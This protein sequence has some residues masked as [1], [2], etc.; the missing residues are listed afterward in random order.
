LASFFWSSSQSSYQFIYQLP[1]LFIETVSVIG[2]LSL[3]ILKLSMGENTLEIV[4]LMGLLALAAFR[5]MPC[6][7]I[8]LF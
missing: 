2:L 3:V 7:T 5:I 1:R 4:P 8:C 6:A